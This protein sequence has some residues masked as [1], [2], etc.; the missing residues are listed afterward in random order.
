MATDN[1]GTRLRAEIAN[2]TFAARCFRETANVMR[3]QRDE[4]RRE[5]RVLRH[6][7]R[8]AALVMV[9]T[10][11]LGGGVVAYHEATEA[12]RLQQLVRIDRVAAE[13][14]ALQAVV[15]GTARSTLLTID[16]GYLVYEVLVAG[17]DGQTHEVTV[18]AGNARVLKQETSKKESDEND[19]QVLFGGSP[20][21]VMT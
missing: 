12:A 21:L 19:D 6:R 15:L 16:D 5:A 10:L 3:S 2:L 13:T 14:A 20:L 7:M 8:I 4:A 18:D 1:D 17:K 9:V 11:L